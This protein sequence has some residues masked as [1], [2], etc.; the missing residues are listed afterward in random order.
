LFEHT[1]CFLYILDF[2]GNKIGTLIHA[3]DA[4]ISFLISDNQRFS[5]SKTGSFLI[6][7][8]VYYLEML[9]S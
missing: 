2:I 4:D 7:D 6:T 3:E 5:A 1:L 9:S 8:K